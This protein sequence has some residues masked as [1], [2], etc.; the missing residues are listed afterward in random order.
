LLFDVP[1]SALDTTLVCS[2]HVAEIPLQSKTSRGIVR[3]CGTQGAGHRCL[4]ISALERLSGGRRTLNR[5]G[6]RSGILKVSCR[7]GF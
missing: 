5:V 4:P 1:A 6:G 7:I 2:R 3:Y